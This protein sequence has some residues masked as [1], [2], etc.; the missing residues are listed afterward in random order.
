MNNFFKICLLSLFLI[1]HTIISAQTSLGTINVPCKCFDTKIVFKY[2]QEEF[3]EEPISSFTSL[4]K[5][6]IF[7]TWTNP[8]DN[9]V[10]LLSTHKDITCIIGIGNDLKFIGIVPA[11]N[12][13]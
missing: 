7:S 6:V 10:T 8:K 13:N 3:K 2:L 1:T 12:L 9:T 11:K 4:E 5:D